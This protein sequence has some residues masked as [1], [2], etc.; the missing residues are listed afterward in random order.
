MQNI[1]YH[2]ATFRD[3][4]KFNIQQG[5]VLKK[6][7]LDLLIQSPKVVEAGGGGGRVLPHFVIPVY[8]ICN[9]TMFLKS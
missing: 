6:M 8:L 5:H 1:C 4:N 3:S 2:V 9:M 7:N